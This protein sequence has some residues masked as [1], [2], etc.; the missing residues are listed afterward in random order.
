MILMTIK[1]E[2]DLLN[3]WYAAQIVELPIR[4]LAV[5]DILKQY[6]GFDREAEII[7]K[8]KDDKSALD[9]EYSDKLIEI[10]SR[11]VHVDD[12]GMFYSSCKHC[13]HTD[14]M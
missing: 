3:A 6:G 10:Q 4:S 12:S 9:A 7:I 14:G 8:H 5:A 13:G 11:C 1:E 2:V